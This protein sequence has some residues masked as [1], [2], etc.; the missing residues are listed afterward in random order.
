[1]FT[2]ANQVLSTSDAVYNLNYQSL[3]SSLSDPI[4]QQMCSNPFD[5][6]KQGQSE[7]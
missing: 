7:A 3:I 4:S 2:P 6:C 5:K 1:M